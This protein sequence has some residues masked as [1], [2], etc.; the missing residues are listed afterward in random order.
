MSVIINNVI[1]YLNVPIKDLFLFLI[2]R[3]FFVQVL[4]RCPSAHRVLDVPAEMRT[5]LE[6]QQQQRANAPG[7]KEGGG[8]DDND[9][10]RD[11]IREAVE[12][13]GQ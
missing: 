7:N 11:W 6:E 10:D 5:R 4:E 12:L 9:G 8:E 3:F 1:K 13:L 2:K